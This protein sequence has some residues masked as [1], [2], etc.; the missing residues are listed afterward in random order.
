MVY[1]SDIHGYRNT[2]KEKSKTKIT[3]KQ[4]KT[5]IIMFVK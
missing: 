4:K 2:I 1:R 5:D 3:Q